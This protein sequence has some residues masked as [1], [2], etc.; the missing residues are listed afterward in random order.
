VSI[1]KEAGC[2]H[3][4]RHIVSLLLSSV[5]LLTLAPTAWAKGKGFK[6]VVKHL[7]SN[8]GARK[9]KVPMLGLANFVVKVIRPAGVKGFKLAVFEDQDFSPRAGEASFLTVMRQ[10]YLAEKGWKPLVQT[11]SK[12]D[13]ALQ[14]AF[15]FFKENKKDVE[16]VVTTLGEREASVIEVSSAPIRWWPSSTTRALW[17]FRLANLC[18]GPWTT[19]SRGQ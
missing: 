15:I 19:P 17:A 12:R 2:Y 3:R 7:Q 13:G 14:R 6:D 8:Y 9:T 16:V 18:A 11:N 10:A 1:E 5:L 4:Y